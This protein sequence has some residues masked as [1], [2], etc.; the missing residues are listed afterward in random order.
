VIVL[1]VISVKGGE[2]VDKANRKPQVN[3]FRCK[4]HRAPCPGA[5]AKPAFRLC[6]ERRGSE[7]NEL[8]PKAEAKNMKLAPTMKRGFFMPCRRE[9][10]RKIQK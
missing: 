10:R 8:S 7:M 6:G 9:Y 1:L 4:R 5:P 3:M 2:P